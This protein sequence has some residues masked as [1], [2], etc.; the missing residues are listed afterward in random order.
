MEILDIYNPIREEHCS[1]AE[2]ALSTN[3]E[4][5]ALLQELSNRPFGS[6]V[7]KDTFILPAG[8]AVVTRVRTLEP[9]VWLSHCHLNTHKE[10]GM[11]LIVNVGNFTAPANPSWLPDDFP[12]CDHP[13]TEEMK[14]EP[15]C[16]CYQDEDAVLNRGLT[17][18]HQ[19]SREYLCGHVMS[20]AANLESYK[21]A[22]V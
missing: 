20:E 18:K 17:A 4:S 7:M 16:T 11:S 9:A 8:G 3:Y 12:S 5:E 13:F 22:G 14:E 19:C 21:P 2:C 1:R 15:A 10:D 6:G